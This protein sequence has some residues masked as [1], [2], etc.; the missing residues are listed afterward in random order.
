MRCSRSPPRPVTSRSTARSGSSAKVGSTRCCRPLRS[1]TTRFGISV[2]VGQGFPGDADYDIEIVGPDGSTLQTLAAR[3]DANGVFRVPYA[4]NGELA[5]GDYV[6]R[7]AGTPTV[8]DDVEAPLLIVLPTFQ[9]Q[10]ASG[11]AFRSSVI[12]T[13]G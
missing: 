5:L 13:R 7:V 9:P 1:A 8:F 2:V 11:P 4:P 6:M 12:V 10:G 3:T